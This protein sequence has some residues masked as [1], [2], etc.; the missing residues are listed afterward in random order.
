[1]H[2]SGSVF[3]G[4][5]RCYRPSGPRYPNIIIDLSLSDEIVDLYLDRTD[6]AFR[7]GPLPI[8]A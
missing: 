1:M 3:T 2:R 4:W 7:I 6:I 8:Q 5:S